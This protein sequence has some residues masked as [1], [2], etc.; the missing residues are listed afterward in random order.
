MST[1]MPEN[2]IESQQ[3]CELPDSDTNFAN[4]HDNETSNN[5]GNKPFTDF[6]KAALLPHWPVLQRRHC[7]IRVSRKR[8]IKDFNP[9]PSSAL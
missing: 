3:N 1:T 5:S 8:F 7:L 9:V 4:D 6:L 2:E